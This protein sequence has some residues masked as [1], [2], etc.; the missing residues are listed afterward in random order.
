MEKNYD[1]ILFGVTG[2]TGKLCA[3]YLFERNYEVKWAASAR[4]P[5][6]AEGVLKDL[7][8]RFGA[9]MPTILEA[10]LICES[11]EQEETLRNVVRQTKVVLT[12]SGPFEK[13]SKSLVKICAEL[14]VY[15]ADITGE[16]DYFRQTIAQHDKKA[17]ETGA[18]IVCHC[19][20]DCIPCDLTVYEMHQFAR[21]KG[22][23]LKEVRTYEEFA[24]NATL[25]GGTITTA[26]FQL[27]KDR[28]KN[29]TDFDPLLS[30]IAGTKS[31]F[32]T[33]NISPKK[34]TPIP[35]MEGRKAGPWVMGP[36]MVNCVRRSNALIGY[37]EDFKYGDAQVQQ[38]SLLGWI[39]QMGTTV[40][41]AGNIALPSVFQYLVPKPGEGPS[42]EDMETGFL[43]LHGYGTMVAKDG[44]EKK[45]ASL[46]QFNKDTGYLYT[47]ALLVETGMLLVEKF[48]SLS[49]G[50]KTPASALGNDLTQRILKEMDSSFE[51]KDL[52]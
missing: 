6:K 24:D 43:K 21:Q 18:V 12:C 44:S 37:S 2:F 10:D 42:R 3:E 48:G 45:L 39:K 1:I 13:Y 19:G 31:Q 8:V 36:V 30:T 32:S 26:T 50:C 9:E 20:N 52:E 11:P 51:V 38:E 27:A 33:K 35:E 25:S 41:I 49:G 16:T 29:S 14:G 46:F 34:E 40:V 23:E 47:A 4:N 17:Q 7:S 22:C 28:K 5:T 15:Y